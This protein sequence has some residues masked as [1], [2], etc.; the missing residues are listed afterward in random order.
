MPL[1][2]ATACLPDVADG[3]SALLALADWGAPL[4]SWSPG[5]PVGRDRARAEERWGGR[6]LLHHACLEEPDGLIWNLA[7]RDEDVRKRSLAMAS[8]AVRHAAVLGCPFYS[9][10]AGFAIETTLTPT[11]VPAGPPSDRTKAYDQLLRSIDSLASV[12]DNHKLPLLLENSARR[13]GLLSVPD[14]V[15]RWFHRLGA[16]HV[17]IL[18][19]TAHWMLMCRIR[20]WEPEEPLEEMKRFVRAIEVHHTDGRQDGHLPLPETAIELALAKQLGGL[21]LPVILEARSLDSRRLEEQAML[22]EDA[23]KPQTSTPLV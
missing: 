14:E 10:H 17:G 20:R 6:M 18:L 11:G 3:A 19:D 23:L 21:A 2:L 1:Y 22:L 5:R 4:A 13:E 8:D 15:E 7:A 16:P 9:L 12:A